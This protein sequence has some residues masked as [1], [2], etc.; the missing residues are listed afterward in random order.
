MTLEKNVMSYFDELDSL[1]EMG[2][3]SNKA[4]LDL[5]VLAVLADG[6]TTEEELAQLDEELLRLPF[7]WDTDARDEVTEHSATTRELLEGNLQ[8]EGVVRG[9]MSSLAKRIESEEL[10]MVALRM[11]ISITMSDGLMETERQLA[12]A[13]GESFSIDAGTVDHLIAQIA[14]TI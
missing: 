9:F 8:D 10:R 14:E 1:K 6:E 5:L 11:F 2:M 3:D 4:F 13:L 12:H 7:I